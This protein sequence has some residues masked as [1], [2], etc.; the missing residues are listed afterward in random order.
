MKINFQKVYQIIML[1]TIQT[2]I[3]KPI[4]HRGDDSI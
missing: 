4:L 3:V 1:W 2:R